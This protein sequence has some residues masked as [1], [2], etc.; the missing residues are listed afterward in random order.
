MSRDKNLLNRL[1]RQLCG[2]RK[3]ITRAL[4]YLP[5]SDRNEID[6][7]RRFQPENI[8]PRSERRALNSIMRKVVR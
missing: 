7:E 2:L 3:K 6:P 1:D 5:E 8:P 4:E